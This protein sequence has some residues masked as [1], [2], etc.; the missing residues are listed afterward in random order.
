M[1][2]VEAVRLVMFPVEAVRLVMLPV[3]AVSDGKGSVLPSSCR[4]VRSC[5]RGRRRAVAVARVGQLA[6]WSMQT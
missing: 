3:E 5:C 4:C 6:G 1:R 2:P